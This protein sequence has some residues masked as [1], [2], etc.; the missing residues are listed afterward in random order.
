MYSNSGTLY[1]TYPLLCVCA[2]MCVCARG[3]V[4]DPVL[5]SILDNPCL[6]LQQTRPTGVRHFLCV[7]GGFC[8]C[9]QSPV[10]CQ[11]LNLTRYQLAWQVCT[12]FLT[13]LGCLLSLLIF[14]LA[15]LLLV[16]LFLYCHFIQL[17]GA[18]ICGDARL[19]R[20]TVLAQRRFTF[21]SL[22]RDRDNSSEVDCISLGNLSSQFSCVLELA[23]RSNAV[24]Q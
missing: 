18:N 10:L 9:F 21:A 11:F 13:F 4:S 3:C 12:E 6:S 19:L 22:V 17:L 14:C 16:L 24:L 15:P 1:S 2:R 23:P 7:L 5:P 8:F 20:I